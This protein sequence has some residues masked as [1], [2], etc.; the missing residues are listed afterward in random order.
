MRDFLGGFDFRGDAALATV[1]RFSGGEKSRLALALIAWQRPN[2]HLLDEPTNNLDIEMR[3]ALTR[4]LQDYEGAMVLVSHDRSL[5]R[6][7][8]D[9]LMLVDEGTVTEFD[10]DV[11]DYTR[12]LASRAA[13]SASAQPA[14]LSRKDQRRLEAEARARF[15]ALRRPL[16]AKLRAVEAEIEHLT[17]KKARLEKLITSPDMYLD[18]R[19]DEMTKCLI[20]Q[21]Q[22]TQ[23]LSQ[24]EEHWLALSGELEALIG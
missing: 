9:A 7:T 14:D 11:D 15:A 12:H 22:V 16:Q 21:A 13:G 3:H 19:R 1:R 20:E 2:V 4:A 10:G 18:S 24:A 5:V 8:C 17:G 6:A 23:R